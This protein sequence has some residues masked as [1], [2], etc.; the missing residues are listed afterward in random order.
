LVGAFSLGKTGDTTNSNLDSS[1]VVAFVKE[2]SQYVVRSRG[3]DYIFGSEEQNRFY[4]DASEKQYNDRLGK[5]V[6]DQVKVLGINKDS[7]LINPLISDFAFQISD[8]I[9]F[10]DGYESSKEIKLSFLD[11]DDDGVIDNPESF[12]QVVGQDLD[13]KYLFFNEVVDQSG[14][15]IYEKVENVRKLNGLKTI[16]TLEKESIVNLNSYDAGQLLYFYDSQE[17]VVK[18]VVLNSTGGKTLALRS[19]YKGVVGRDKLK[20][21]YIHNASVDRRI[22]PSV[23]NIMDVFLLTRSYDE[24]YRI[25]LAGG[26]TVEPEAPTTDQLKITFGSKLDEIKSISDEIIYHPVKYK[27]LFG[28]TASDKLQAQFKIV[29]NSSQNINDN[30][31]KVRIV[32]SINTFFDVNNW[33]F[34]DRFY[35]SELITYVLNQTAPDVSNMVIV[36][37]QSSQ[38]FGSLFEIQSGP[39]ELFVSG[40][41]V[42]DIEIVSSISAVEI[43]VDINSVVTTT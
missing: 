24:A 3:L 15:R 43:G 22:D 33:D 40:A 42:D 37:R 29:K 36:P 9:K 20:F 28:K 27:P 6:K 5:V 10:D 7:A 8:T 2:A 19:S 11:T 16:E 31:L 23:S 39:D 14:S 41:T 4:F 30:D 32:N 38:S 25:Y 17:D 1:W 35:V 34:G 26:T 18:E 12:E 13:F 21:Q